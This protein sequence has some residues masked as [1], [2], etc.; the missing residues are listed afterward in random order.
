MMAKRVR[1]KTKTK[2]VGWM[3]ARRLVRRALSH[4][5]TYAR[6]LLFFFVQAKCCCAVCGVWC[7]VR[8]VW[9]VEADDDDRD[10]GISEWSEQS[11]P[12]ARSTA[13]AR[14]RLERHNATA[15]AA[16]G[17]ELQDISRELEIVNVLRSGKVFE[18]SEA[19]ILLQMILDR[20]PTVMVCVAGGCPHRCA[21]LRCAVLC[22]VLLA[23]HL[24][25]CCAVL[26]RVMWWCVGM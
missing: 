23:A 3:M 8:G 22:C 18:D 10:G 13:N 21:A 6:Q 15:S 2:R 17:G 25:L 14:E 16:D 4:T 11:K 12:R 24:L 19:K 7:V 5:P 9:C 20:D 1:A 26:Y